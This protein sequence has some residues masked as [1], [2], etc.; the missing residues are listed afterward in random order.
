MDKINPMSHKPWSIHHEKVLEFL[1]SRKKG[2]HPKEAHSRLAKYGFNE[3]QGEKIPG[4]FSV[5]LSQIKNPMAVTLGIAAVICLV[6]QERLDAGAILLILII[7]AIIGYLQEYKSISALAALKRLSAPKVR[8]IREGETLVVPSESVVPGDIIQIEAGDLVSADSRVIE[9]FQLTA[10]EASLTGESQ[11]VEKITDIMESETSVSDRQNMLHSGTS[12]NSGSGLAVVT[13]TGME[14]EIGK[15]AGM[16]NAQAIE[17]TPLQEKLDAVTK[18]LIFLGVL[19]ILVVILLGLADEKDPFTI[20]MSGISLAVAAIPEGLPTVVTL[21]LTLAVRRMT[22]RKAIV[23]NL[24]AVEALG[25]VD[26]ICTDKTGTLTRGVMTAV[27]HELI[28]QS[29]EDLFYQAIVL[30]NNASLSGGAGDSTE[31]ALLEYSEKNGH[32]I[33]EIKNRFGRT[34]EWSFDSHRKRMSVRVRDQSHD[35]EEMIFVKGAPEAMMAVSSL[36]SSQTDT[37]TKKIHQHS[38][39]G[40]RILGIGYK[41]SSAIELKEAES[42]LHF[43]GLIMLSDPPREESI[44]A[45]RECQSAGIRVVMITG[46][47]EQTAHSIAHSLG[48]LTPHHNKVLT[49]KRIDSLAGDDLAALVEE[50]AVYARVSP[51]HKLKI[52]KAL[53]SNHH[54]VAMTG[55][56]VNDAPALKAAQIGISMGKG[57]TEVA[58]QASSIVLMDDNFATIVSAIE[59]GRAIYGNIRQS[60]QYLLS[61]NLSEIMIVLGSSLLHMD[62]PFS[63]MGLLWINLVTDGIPALALAA[64]P[65]DRNI[66]IESKKPNPKSFFDRRFVIEM[67]FVGVLMTV[68]GLGVYY[69]LLQHEDIVKAKSWAFTLIVFLCL[70]RSFSC[71]S[72]VRTFFQLKPNYYH[73]GAVIFTLA[74]HSYFQTFELFEDVFDVQTLSLRELVYLFLLSLIPSTLVECAKLITAWRL[75][76]SH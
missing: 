64:E 25:S 74:L 4:R 31:T 33:K 66:L 27:N 51:S 42:D 29:Q 71:R 37:L 43:L 41:K 17:K 52:I 62:I 5:L 20:F 73:M 21:A 28:D 23:R 9:A 7:N 18:N 32:P 70:S 60:I 56:G 68:I 15:I 34:H 35:G 13:R 49:G 48:I 11:P 38:S 22:R 69:Y 40:L 54:V 12:I 30:C 2:L 76:K 67:T 3:L 65:L 57:G 50:T 8:V 46:D 53:Q 19:V 16:L 61:T 39:Q 63:P 58:R 6:L 47:H 1:G 44:S 36:S 45:I 72:E 59:E 14:T 26:V 55:D 75:K 24:S 10:D